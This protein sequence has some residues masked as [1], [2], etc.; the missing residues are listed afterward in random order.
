MSHPLIPTASIAAIGNA[1]IVVPDFGGPIR[2]IDV[3][4]VAQ[5]L[6]NAL[7][8]LSGALF[9]GTGSLITTGSTFTVNV[10][11]L[12][13]AGYQ[14]A[15]HTSITQV[16]SSG[17][18]D[19]V[20]AGS[21]STVVSIGPTSVS[22][23]QGDGVNTIVVQGSPGAG[24]QV[25]GSVDFK[26]Q[27]NFRDVVVAGSTF[28]AVGFIESDAGFTTTGLTQ[29]STLTAFS[30]ASLQGPVTRKKRTLTFG[31]AHSLNLSDY[32]VIGDTTG[33]TFAVTLPPAASW[34][35]FDMLTIVDNGFASTNRL[36]VNASGAETICGIN[37]IDIKVNY[38]WM[39]I[40]STGTGW[41]GLMSGTSLF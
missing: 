31:S 29:T 20:A 32:V 13:Q 35:G 18:T 39:R 5:P 22:V 8:F 30:S 12:F 6:N 25:T 7:T 37:S 27:L 1:T 2:S 28:S 24:Y 4:N 33:G 19:I 16:G 14:D 26:N 3:F 38:G 15:T 17:M 9:S 34:V 40:T 21:N 10:T 23:T 36:T 41:V 11:G